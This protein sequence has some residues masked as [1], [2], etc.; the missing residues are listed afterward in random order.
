MNST[1]HLLLIDD[2]EDDARLIVTQ[3]EK[4]DYDISY[5]RIASATAMEQALHDPS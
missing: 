3:L 4:G 1:L 2:S 5:K